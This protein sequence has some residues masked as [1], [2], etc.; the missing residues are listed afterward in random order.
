MGEQVRALLDGTATERWT[1]LQQPR[2]RFISDDER[3]VTT[4][5]GIKALPSELELPYNMRGIDYLLG[6]PPYV[7]AGESDENLLYR[8]AIWNFGVYHFLHQ[9]WDLFVPF[10]ERN[11]QFLRPNAGRLSLIVSRGIETEGYAK[12]LRRLLSTQYRILQIDFFPRLRLFQDAAIENTIVTIEN[13]MPDEEHEVIRRKHLQA[14]CQQFETLPPVTQLEADEQLFRWRYDRALDLNMLQGSIPLCA[15]VYIGTGVEAQSKESLD[16]TVANK[17]QKLFTL[18]NVFLEQNAKHPTRPTEYVDDGV[19][20]ND[21][22]RYYLRRMRYVAYEKYRPQ[23]RR[24]RHIALFRTTEKLLLGETSGGYY[25]RAGLFANHSVQVVVP[26]A[27]LEASRATE[28]KGIK[29]VLRESRQIVGINDDLSPIS[30]LFDLRYLLGIINSQFIR[31]YLA[32]NKLEGTREGR[33]YPDV[34]KRLPIK[35]AP[36]ERQRQVA[37]LVDTIQAHYKQLSSLATPITLAANIAHHSR[38]IQSYLARGDIR[39]V[40]ESSTTIA[41]RPMLRDG[42]L[43]LRRQPLAYLEAPDEP[44]LLRYVELYLTQLHPEL[45]K[46]SWAQARQQIQVPPT[47]EAVH[48]FML[49]IDAIETQKQEMRTTITALLA[50]VEELVEAIYSEPADSGKMESI[51]KLRKKNKGAELF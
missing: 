21:V 31:R 32:A 44:G 16:P 46:L 38:S 43:M 48:E 27:A 9:R 39:F 2:G 37:E 20:G 50:E 45:Q 29:T 5:K 28:E 11:L 1:L 10:F 8:T 12:E 15:I 51:D 34:W 6:N 30:A 23:M 24:P 3:A 25:D 19:L 4:I 35:V 26:W 22:D 47:L 13:G 33:I 14:D 17:R 36:D 42:H 49:A 7:S 40:G 18:D 41:E